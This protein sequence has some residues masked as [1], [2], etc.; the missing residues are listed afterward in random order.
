VC[1][2]PPPVRGQPAAGGGL[3][4]GDH[5]GPGARGHPGRPE[6]M[7]SAGGGGAPGPP[8]NRGRWIPPPHREEI[9]H[10][11]IPTHTPAGI[12]TA[13]HSC[14]KLVNRNHAIL[15]PSSRQQQESRPAGGIA[16]TLSRAEGISKDANFFGSRMESHR[17][18]IVSLVYIKVAGVFVS[19]RGKGG[20]GVCPSSPT[21]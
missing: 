16:T 20:E 1:S 3:P 14:L 21:P 6:G 18:P 11:I 9:P 10:R 5:Y 4:R 13:W 7:R 17:R 12:V 19:I 15:F 2:Q 8:P